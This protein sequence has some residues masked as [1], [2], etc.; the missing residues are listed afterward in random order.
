MASCPSLRSKNVKYGNDGALYKKTRKEGPTGTSTWVLITKVPEVSALTKMSIS[1]VRRQFERTSRGG[2]R[3]KAFEPNLNRDR[4]SDR[5]HPYYV[6]SCCDRV[7]PHSS[8]MTLGMKVLNCRG[9]YNER[10][11]THWEY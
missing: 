8:M 3:F 5:G 2:L 11:A 7:M 6:C 1:T 4:Y 9:C 10:Y